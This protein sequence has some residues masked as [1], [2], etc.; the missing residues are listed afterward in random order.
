MIIDFR[1]R[2]PFKGYENNFLF[3]HLDRVGEDTRIRVDSE[4]APSAKNFS[5]P[6]LLEEADAAGVTRM[7]VPMRRNHGNFNRE[8]VELVETW[9]DTF[10]GLAGINIANLTEAQEEIRRYVAEGPLKGIVLEPG[11]DSTPWFA[12]AAWALPLYAFCEEAGVPVVFTFGGIMTRSLRYYDP[13][14]ID[15]IAGAFPRLKIALCHGGWPY[16]TECCQIALNRGN[17]WLAPDIYMVR[18]PGMADYVMAANHLLRERIIFA[19]A[20]PILPLDK[21]VEAYR[22]CGIS[23]ASLPY[24]MGKNAAAFLG[25]D[26]AGVAGR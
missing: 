26:S 7:V 18:S 2:A 19:S 24:V 9:P 1:V 12:N 23:E 20:Y 4:V 16:V 3:T 13:L 6:T 11:Q 8:L 17:V 21:A 15:D 5:L 10:V 22:S 14:L 25:L